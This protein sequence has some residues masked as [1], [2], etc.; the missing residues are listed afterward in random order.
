[1]V[2]SL[3]SGFQ[4]GAVLFLL[5]LALYQTNSCKWYMMDIT[6]EIMY[7]YENHLVILVIHY[8]LSF[9]AVTDALK[10]PKQCS[11]LVLF[12]MVYEA[13]N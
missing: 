7:N 2:L 4:S 3:C 13:S 11:T 6:N 8:I 1:M 5:S 10:T 9:L 12:R